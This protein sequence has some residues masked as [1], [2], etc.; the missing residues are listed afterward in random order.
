MLYA[1]CALLFPLQSSASNREALSSAF[2]LSHFPPARY[3][4]TQ[5]K[6]T[7][8]VLLLISRLI[9]LL[10]HQFDWWSQLCYA[11]GLFEVVISPPAPIR[12]AQGKVAGD[13]RRR[14]SKNSGLWRDKQRTQ[15]D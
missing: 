13:V 5:T 15:S 4:F 10:N 14:P 7:S 3:A 1:L 6:K 11:G 12:Q 8:T 2:P 9:N